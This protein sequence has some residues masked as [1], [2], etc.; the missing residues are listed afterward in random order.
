MTCPLFPPVFLQEC[1]LDVWTYEIGVQSSELPDLL[2]KLESLASDPDIDD[3]YISQNTLDS[4]STSHGFF[5]VYLITRSSAKVQQA[6]RMP[7]WT[8]NIKAYHSE[9]PGL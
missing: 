7:S 1:H 8:V 6:Q 3:W 9:R 2:R 5:G 4:V